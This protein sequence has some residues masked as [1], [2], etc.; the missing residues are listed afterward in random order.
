MQVSETFVP[1][2]AQWDMAESPISGQTISGEQLCCV[3]PRIKAVE[4]LHNGDGI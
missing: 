4:N 1:L 2:G 3:V